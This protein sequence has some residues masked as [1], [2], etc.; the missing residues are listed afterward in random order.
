MHCM[1]AWFPGVRSVAAADVVLPTVHTV[2]AHATSIESTTLT[3]P[4]ADCP[5]PPPALQFS[6]L[7]REVLHIPQ[8]GRIEFKAEFS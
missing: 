1:D 6:A 4:I 3:V 5:P 7:L 2:H 8:Y